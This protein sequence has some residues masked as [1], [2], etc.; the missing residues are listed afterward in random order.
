MGQSHD[1]VAERQP[2]AVRR[3]LPCSPPTNI[4]RTLPGSLVTCYSPLTTQHGLQSGSPGQSRSNLSPFLLH[5]QP[6][7]VALSYVTPHSSLNNFLGVDHSGCRTA[8]LRIPKASTVFSSCASPSPQQP[9]HT[10][11]LT[12]HSTIS[13][14]LIARAAERAPCALCDISHAETGS[15]P[16]LLIPTHCSIGVQGGGG[17]LPSL[18]LREPRRAGVWGF[19]WRRGARAG[20]GGGEE[21]RLE[22]SNGRAEARCWEIVGK[23]KGHWKRGWWQGSLNGGKGT[24]C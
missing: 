8:T 4:L 6:S 17:E 5:T 16:S 10:L 15:R 18:L 23:G 3:H 24:D 21:E 12:Y 22:E 14:G 2:R 20:R 9:R 7:P 1:S 19:V 11:L 13:S